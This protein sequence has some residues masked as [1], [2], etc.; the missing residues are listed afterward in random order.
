MI[1]EPVRNPVSATS[2]ITGL[3]IPPSH[4]M[5]IY[6]AAAG[7][8]ISIADLFIAGIVP[9]VFAGLLLMIAAYFVAVRRGYPRGRFPGFRAFAVALIV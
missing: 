3:L 7:V 8:S 5:I 9:G 1:N 6:A 2:A 4:N